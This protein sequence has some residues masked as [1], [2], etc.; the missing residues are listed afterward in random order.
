MSEEDKDTQNPLSLSDEDIANFD[1]SQLDQIDQSKKEESNDDDSG[2]EETLQQE[3]ETNEEISDEVESTEEDESETEEES[4]E[5]QDESTDTET[6]EDEEESSEGQTEEESSEEQKTSDVDYRA[7]YEKILAPFKANGREIHVDSVDDAI[8]LMQMGANYNKKM[9]ALK[10]NLKLV[11]MLQNNDLLSEEKL[12]HLID[13]SKQNPQAINKLLKDSN[14]DPMDIN[15]EDEATDSYTPNTYNVNDAEVE[16]DQ[17]LAEIK[18]T[19]KF[20]VTADIIGNKWDDYSK[21]VLLENPKVITTIN[22]HIHSGV[23]D[24]VT[25][26]VERERML[27]RLTGLSDIEAY[28]QVGES[29]TANGQIGSSQAEQT[30]TDNTAPKKTVDP[31]LKSRKKAAS[32][33][34]S[35]PKKKVDKD[36]NPLSMSDEEFEKLA[37][38]K[39]F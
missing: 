10:P 36:F 27:G 9:A 38:N 25:A 20:N 31:K 19:P 34:K 4:E 29:L 22:E 21:K 15:L 2:E 18:D 14:I 37:A 5:S 32:T 12:N 1:L 6:G 8:T 23:Y 39:Y 28:K 30:H 35:S 33:T 3:E 13:L 16:L 17:V 24:Q 26:V 7:E 11:K